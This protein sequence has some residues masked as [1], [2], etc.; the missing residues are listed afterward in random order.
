M[1]YLYIDGFIFYI[2][3]VI[4]IF[5]KVRLFI[6]LRTFIEKFNFK[7]ILFI[8]DNSLGMI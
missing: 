3:F 2:F 1:L 5:N 8:M 6:I 7:S 4:L